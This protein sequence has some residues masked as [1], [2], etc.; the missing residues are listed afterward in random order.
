MI[1]LEELRIFSNLKKLQMKLEDRRKEEEEIEEIGEDSL[2]SLGF[3]K[4]IRITT[5]F[6]FQKLVR[7]LVLVW[8]GLLIE[9][10]PVCWI[11]YTLEQ[12][13]LVFTFVKF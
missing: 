8:S 4:R 12:R 7:F 10:R 3:G 1:Q 9:N 11:P 6:L 13:F 2:F 5:E